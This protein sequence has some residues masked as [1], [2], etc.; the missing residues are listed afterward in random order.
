M[1]SWFA[2]IGKY[3]WLFFAV[4][5][6]VL[7]VTTLT[8]RKA[9]R[10]IKDRIRSW[11]LMA[12]L[13]TAA[14]I[15]N[16]TT[17]ILFFALV[18]FLALKE[19]ITIIPTRR[20]DRRVLFWTYL[21]IIL[22]YFWVSIHWYGMFA[23]FIPVFLFLFIPIRMVLLGKT[24]GF[25]RA[26]G[27]IQWVTMLS[28]YCVSYVAF[29]GMLPAEGSDPSA[30]I[31]LILYLVFL[32]QSNDVAQYC[33]GKT[34]GR[35]K[36]VPSISPN[37]TVVGFVGGACTTTALAMLLAPFFTPLTV[38][39]SL[40]GGLIIGIGGFLGDLTMS[41]VKRDLG[42]KDTSTLIPGHGGVLDRIDSLIFTAPLFF[43]FIRYL[44][45]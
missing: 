1:H 36:I 15:I 23:I 6:A 16:Q 13:L 21:S 33:W 3:N 19:F 37:K 8:S 44:H 9:N 10:E 4:I 39:Q 11:W 18:S 29:L 35:K 32:T 26:S 22:Q 41:A 12:S 24:E 20:V 43:H 27:T 38:L 28:V 40:G 30:R 31:G 45:Y 42:I 5:Y 17:M 34:L 7:I 14:L 25:L 2:S